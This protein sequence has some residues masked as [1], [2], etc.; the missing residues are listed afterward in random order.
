MV[1]TKDE[2]IKSLEDEVRVLLHLVS[3]VEPGMLDYRP[4]AK[5]RSML[6]LLQYMVIMGPIHLR[7]ATAST[8]DMKA[9]EDMWHTEEAAVK[10]MNL[11]QVKDA[12][13]KQP[14]LFT[15]VLASCSDSDFR[16]EMEMFGTRASRGSWIVRLVLCHYAAYRMQLFLYLKACGREELNTM[17]LWV[18]ADVPM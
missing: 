11:Q 8:F 2:L 12:I 3:K 10:T 5:Q 13:A 15:D 6:E 9:W 7:G 4:T 18:G 1:L 14:A 17:N 16:T